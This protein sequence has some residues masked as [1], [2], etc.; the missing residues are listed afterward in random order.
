MSQKLFRD[1]L[2][3][4]IVIDLNKDKWLL[5]L[6]DSREVQ[7]LRY[8]NHLGLSHFTYPG[9]T[10]SRFSHSLG[11]LHLMQNCLDHLKKDYPKHVKKEEREALL[12]ASLLH[13]IGHSPFSHATESFF[14]NHEER[15]VKIITNE[16]SEV[17]TILKNV[18]TYLPNKVASLISKIPRKGLM[19][20]PL[21]QKSLISSQ[22]DMDRLD[23][24]RRDSLHSG[25]EY[26]NFDLLRIIYT[27]QL[28]EKQIKGR[29]RELWNVWPDKS[30][31]ALE[32][33][34]FSRFYMYQGV[35]FHHTT[36]AFE[37]LIRQILQRARDL[38]ETK[39]D[40]VQS[41]LPGIMIS[42]EK[43]TN[44][45][46][47]I[48]LTDHTLIAQIQVWTKSKDNILK[49]LSS[50]L[51]CRKGIG[52]HE[53][54]EIPPNVRDKENKACEYLKSKKKNP[55]YYLLKDSPKTTAYEPYRSA[56]EDEDFSPVT[57][58]I[59]FESSWEGTG[60]REISDVP[61]LER[62]KAIT[63]EKPRPIIRYYFPKEHE[64]EIKKILS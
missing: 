34:I 61:G 36:K 19:Q 22:L 18:N 42:N 35:Y 12:A 21:W 59:L 32:E 62:I 56:S 16:K 51:M 29:Q 5:D 25:A 52:W 49:D 50:R 11:V 44:L 14:G 45:K 37:C 30:K 6:I 63:A 41:I 39:R 47:F 3:D 48:T 2:Y 55:K 26:G 33:Y 40:F 4:Y 23:Y 31:Y 10:H 53:I 27:M 9:A 13:D 46:D 24:L 38:S 60:F 54:S 58:I 8:I 7:R 20:P 15:A 43:E 28:E 64:S 1:P 57:S 17:H